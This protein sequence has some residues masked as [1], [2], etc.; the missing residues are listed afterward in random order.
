MITAREAEKKASKYNT[1]RYADIMKLINSEAERG[2][3]EITLFEKKYPDFE[4]DYFRN[5]GYF[6]TIWGTLGKQLITIKWR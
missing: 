2:R 3:Y 4:I 1:N 5:L 6:V